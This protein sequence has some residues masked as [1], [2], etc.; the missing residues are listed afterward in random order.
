[1]WLTEIIFIHTHHS[2]FFPVVS[3]AS[4]AYTHPK[5]ALGEVTGGDADALFQA[6]VLVDNSDPGCVTFSFT[7]ILTRNWCTCSED[8]CFQGV[9]TRPW[10]LASCTID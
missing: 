4:H 2:T 1:M 8:G 9:L 6:S 3:I 10:R 7:V 5:Q